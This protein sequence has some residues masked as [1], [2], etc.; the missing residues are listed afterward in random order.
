MSKDFTLLAFSYIT[1]EYSYYGSCIPLKHSHL[2]M[3]AAS[4]LKHS[5]LLMGAASPWNTATYSWVLHPP[6]TQLLTHGCCIPL[7]H[8]HLL[9]GAAS[10][11]NTATYSW[12]LHPPETQPLTHGC[13]IPLKH[14]YLLMGAA[15]PWN[16]ATYSWVLYPPW[17][18]G[19]C[20]PLK[21]WELYP[22]ETL[23]AAHPWNTGSCIPLKHWELHPPETLATYSWVLYPPETLGAAHPWNTGSSIP[24]KH[25]ELHPP[26]PLAT[27]SWVLHPPEHCRWRTLTGTR[28]TASRWRARWT[29]RG[30]AP[31]CLSAC[32]AAA[33]SCSARTPVWS[34]WWPRTYTRPCPAAP[35]PYRTCDSLSFRWF[36]DSPLRSRPAP[37]GE[38]AWY[39]FVWLQ[40]EKIMEI[41]ILWQKCSISKF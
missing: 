10:P 9:M 14:S 29:P 23:G 32:G 40:R 7:K 28:H 15:T 25:W 38:A 12:V 26:E 31:E 34:V 8:S 13:C 39:A 37:T 5:H 35:V 21:H 4:P 20:I 11:W 41:V 22:P 16:T 19:S 36:S 6:E 2:L 1:L 33:G 18:T 30:P 24:L 3:G 17:N 27:Y